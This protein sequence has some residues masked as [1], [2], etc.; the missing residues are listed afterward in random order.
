MIL[1]GI[2]IWAV[3]TGHPVVAVMLVLAALLD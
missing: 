1:F 2:F 3:F